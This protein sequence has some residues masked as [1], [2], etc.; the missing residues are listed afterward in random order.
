[1]TTMRGNKTSTSEFSQ[2][3]QLFVF[4]GVLFLLQRKLPNKCIYDRPRSSKIIILH[5]RCWIG[6]ILK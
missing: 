1:M 3:L 5:T 2:S 4:F 6:N